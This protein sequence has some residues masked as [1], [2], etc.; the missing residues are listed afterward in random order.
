MMSTEEDTS[1]EQ[2]TLLL[3]SYDLNSTKKSA[4]RTDTINIFVKCFIAS[5]VN[6]DIEAE[7]KK[8]LH[9][10]L[11]ATYGQ[12]NVTVSYAH[13]AKLVEDR[14]YFNAL[15]RQKCNEMLYILVD[16][17]GFLTQDK[18]A[19][20]ITFVIDKDQVIG[21]FDGSY[22]TIAYDKKYNWM[23]PI[24]ATLTV[25]RLNSLK[26]KDHASTVQNS[27][28]IGSGELKI[29]IPDVVQTPECYQK[30]D[31]LYVKSIKST[32]SGAE[33][34]VKLD[35]ANSQLIVEVNETSYNDATVDVTVSV[36]AE[37][38]LKID[39]FKV[40]LYFLAIKVEQ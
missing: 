3:E 16:A 40:S 32:I 27:Y 11:E 34:A 29:Q 37:S 17:Y 13:I 31:R 24:S 23:I 39:D 2:Y 19:Q 33:E 36:T 1:P 28:I 14:F 10:K 5:S 20:T 26:F 25:C 9:I 21:T 12:M 18:T 8:A 30:F 7:L 22:M 38:G 4:L 15:Q 6:N 35:N